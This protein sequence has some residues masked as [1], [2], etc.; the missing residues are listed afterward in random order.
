MRGH[1]VLFGDPTRIKPFLYAQ[2]NLRKCLPKRHPRI[3]LSGIEVLG[4]RAT[5]SIGRFLIPLIFDFFFGFVWLRVLYR[6]KGA[7]QI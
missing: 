7:I 6:S 3:R 4:P 2:R 5:G 1:A